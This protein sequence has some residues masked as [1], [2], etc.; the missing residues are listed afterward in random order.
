MDYEK[1]CSAI[2]KTNYE[3]LELFQQD[4]IQC[5]LTN[6]TVSRHISN[7]DFFIN[8]FLKVL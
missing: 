1:E 3:L 4:L 5:G 6:R 2:R 7:V 8:T